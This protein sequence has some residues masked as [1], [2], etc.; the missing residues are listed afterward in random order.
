MVL[1]QRIYDIDDLWELSHRD[2]M[3]P[4]HY[5]LIGGEL[6][7]LSPP[8]GRHGQLQVRLSRYLDIFAEV[9]SLGVVTSD[10]GYH[11]PDNRHT[12]LSPDVAFVSRARAPQP[13]PEK[14][15]PLMPDLAVEIVSPGNTRKEVNRKTQIYLSNGSQLVWIV[16]PRQARVEVYRRD[17]RQGIKRKTAN[18]SDILSGEDVLPGFELALQRLFSP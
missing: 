18:A 9:Q 11:P 7:V 4:R 13:F 16:L 15:V 8:G 2:V 6:I 10:A 12:L 17:E 3:D 14:Y 5:E 1:R